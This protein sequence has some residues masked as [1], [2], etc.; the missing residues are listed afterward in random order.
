[1]YKEPSLTPPA[2]MYECIECGNRYDDCMTC[3]LTGET[4]WY[5]VPG[6]DDMLCPL[7]A[8]CWICDDRSGTVRR[9]QNDRMCKNCVSHYC[10][11]C[12]T[13]FPEPLNY[14]DPTEADYEAHICD[15]CAEERLVGGDPVR[16]K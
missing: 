5:E 12:D 1:M 16:A 11:Y 8:T 10:G 6:S 15:P 2:Q 9:I 4:L 14:I 3:H 13:M 7:C